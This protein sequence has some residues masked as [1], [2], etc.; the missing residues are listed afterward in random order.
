MPP[1]LLPVLYYSPA[2]A[3]VTRYN[4]RHIGL[5][6]GTAA[7][8]AGFTIITV[9]V[10]I[11]LAFAMAD[12]AKPEVDILHGAGMNTRAPAECTVDRE[13]RM[14]LQAGAPFFE[15]L[16]KIIM[17]Y[18]NPYSTSITKINPR[19]IQRRSLRFPG[20]RHWFYFMLQFLGYNR[21]RRYD[22]EKRK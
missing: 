7:A 20:I 17:H 18:N 1:H 19:G 12:R 3:N 5:F 9:K 16:F 6:P 4:L 13:M 15:F 14:V 8:E 11:Q 22:S 10:D 2:S 21:N